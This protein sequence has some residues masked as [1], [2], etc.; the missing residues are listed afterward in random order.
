MDE[1]L[2]PEEGG[3][4]K[5]EKSISADLIRGH[6]NTI[7]L[8]A[9]YD[10]DKYGY[11]I[12][13]E[14]ERKSHGQYTLK[15]PSLYSALKRLEK[16]GYVSSYWGGS[17]GGGRRK[18]FSLTEEG[19]EIAETNQAEWEYSLTV[20]D[21]RIS[22]KAF[23]FN[24]PAPTAVN[25]R[26]LRS[27]TSRVPGRAEEDDDLDYEPSFDDSAERDRLLEE[28][29]E[30][31]KALET[32][33]ADFES[34]KAAYAQEYD[35]REKELSERERA[36][37][38]QRKELEAMKADYDSMVAAR[39]ADDEAS[40][41][42]EEAEFD[43]RVRLF[44]AEE[45]ER[46]KE[47][48]EAEAER[49]RL[50]E[51]ENA[52]RKA[53]LEAEEADRRAALEAEEAERRAAIEAEEADRRAAYEA[54]EADKRAALEAEEAERRAAIEAEE[55]DKRAAY[56]AEEADKRAALEAELNDMRS[57]IA[58]EEAQRRAALDAEE[59]E[60]RRILDE[61][62]Q[63]R[64]QSIES[65]ET[66]RKEALDLELALRK[67]T[68]DNE[69][70][71]RRRKFEEE[72]ADQRKALE[73]KDGE[74]R[75]REQQLLA[76]ECFLNDE[77]NH[78]NEML[79]QRD[80]QLQ[81][82]RTSHEQA[83]AAL[84]QSHES[85]MTAVRAYYQQEINHLNYISLI[86]NGS[87]E[88]RVLEEPAAGPRYDAYPGY[89]S[90]LD[91]IYS[92]AS[93]RPAQKGAVL[94]DGPEYGDLET[95]SPIRVTAVGGA[96]PHTEPQSWS[97]V[98]RGKALFLSA[99]V[100]FFLCL[101]EGVLTLVLRDRYALPHFYPI[102]IIGAGVTLV[103]VTGLA[104]A[105]RYGEGSLRRKSRALLNAGVVYALCVII[106]FIVALWVKIDFTDVSAVATYVV[107]PIVFFFG[108][109]VFGV[110][111]F[112]LTRPKKDNFKR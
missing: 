43:E 62:L 21:S 56:E 27:S 35:S 6:I 12:I 31:N 104:Y 53:A 22:D 88:G 24:N 92:R 109:L 23:D 86:N 33:K 40:F 30:R 17:V 101:L 77:R 37:E 44:E 73:Q 38:E 78:Y 49:A 16:D 25:M 90:V 48:A 105:N 102:F 55:A 61:E 57:A 18:Y 9:L 91:P 106:T 75:S 87:A 68:M 15:Q 94:I 5:E 96:A 99:I 19:K 97:L 2:P 52:A 103:L 89:R 4:E 82:E 8:R 70:A 54:E 46:R 32:E 108:I 111:Y 72:D 81:S 42:A 63:A 60:R 79:R 98:H 47:L 100:V 36:L 14:I 26:V 65:E 39:Q 51:D 84:N 34:E 64:K 3:E 41:A 110:C 28:F 93:G 13:A 69:E 95:G 66:S 112:F 85:E 59:S 7:I 67:Q 76:R 80:E 29:E 1:E 11:A 10:G 50:I 74:L 45:E 20:I 71:A 83:I 58:D 107:V